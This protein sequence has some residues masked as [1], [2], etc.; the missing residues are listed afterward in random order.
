MLI[1]SGSSLEICSHFALL[2]P[3]YQP[4][5]LLQLWQA[6][7]PLSHT[8]DNSIRTIV[9]H[10]QSMGKKEGNAHDIISQVKLA[11]KSPK[12][13]SLE[14]KVCILELCPQ[15]VAHL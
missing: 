6:S 5:P 9:L 10:V 15:M 4:E 2:L 1:N 13:S 3:V 11:P 8:D 12:Q 14:L 7:L